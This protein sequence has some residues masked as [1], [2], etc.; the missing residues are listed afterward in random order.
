MQRILSIREKLILILTAG[1]IVCAISFNLLIEPVLTKNAA[2][3][4]EINIARSKLEKYAAL[5]SRKDY[6]HKEYNKLTL[7]LR[8][9]DAS[10]DTFLD[11]LTE[12]ENL[13]RDAK[14]RIIDVRPQGTAKR[15]GS[16]KE[17]LI[18]LRT[19]GDLES[20]LRFIYNT[21]NSSFLL[22]IDNFQLNSKANSQSLEGNFLI[23]QISL[24]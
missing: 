24:D 18:E 16:E 15:I 3:N 4:K 5:L 2:L 1:I 8:R 21:E 14:I 12:I 20:Y 17:S 6:I 19:E 13:A 9:G 22:T 23:S 11:L 10:K 7:T